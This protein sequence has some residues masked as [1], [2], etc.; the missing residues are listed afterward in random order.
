[1]AR[2]NSFS[3]TESG[4]TFDSVKNTGMA[5]G[6]APFTGVSNYSSAQEKQNTGMSFN[7]V[8]IDWNGAHL[9]SSTIIN[10]TGELLSYISRKFGS[11]SSSNPE[12]IH[13]TFT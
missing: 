5:A 7:A 1:M 6:G 10:T 8:D 3:Y 9:G 13:I 11:G 4:I 2:E 12:S